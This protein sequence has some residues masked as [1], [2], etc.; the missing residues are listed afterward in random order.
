MKIEYGL[1]Q[2][3]QKLEGKKTKKEY[4]KEYLELKESDLEKIILL[5]AKDLPKHYQKQLE[6]FQD[7]RLSDVTISVIPDDLW[8]KG[9]QPSESNAETQLIFIKQSYFETQKDPDEIAWLCHE[10]AHCQNF[11]DSKSPKNYQDNMTKF[12]FNDLK[13]KYTYPNNLVEEFAFTKQFK[14]LKD[15]GKTKEDILRMIKKYY[16]EDDFPFFNRLLNNIY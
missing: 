10:L 14:L 15:R 8:I 7:E 4:I 12:A 1:K 16:K 2:L 5:K 3:N 11:L 9:E 13:T 6:Y